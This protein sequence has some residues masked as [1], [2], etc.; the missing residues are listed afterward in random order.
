MEG[1]GRNRGGLG[2]GLA[3]VQS[4]ASL[5][6]HPLSLTSV[7]G[8]GSRFSVTVPRGALADN[9]EP[10]PE[11]H[12]ALP[13]A[14]AAGSFAGLRVLVIDDDEL[15]LAGTSSLLERWGCRVLPAT[16]GRQA[17]ERMA[18]AGGQVDLV[19]SDLKLGGGE[20]G[21]NVISELR[22]A[23][24]GHLPALILTGDR[25][26]QTSRDVKRRGLMLL[27]KPVPPSRLK[28]LMGQ[29]LEAR[30]RAAA[31]ADARPEAGLA[32]ARP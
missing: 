3:I 11:P 7:T 18:A 1:E 23:F 13:P 30:P 17:H 6:G 22:A 5:L 4:C 27:Y 29:L 20:M 19:V 9:K 21:T 28:S 24:D 12:E 31:R 8:R 25:S 14:G 10:S 2:L 26:L 32:D 16:S 15:L